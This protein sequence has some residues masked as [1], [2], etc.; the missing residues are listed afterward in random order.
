MNTDVESIFYRALFSYS[1]AYN[2]FLSG[3]L[4]NRENVSKLLGI[5]Y[6]NLRKQEDDTKDS[7]VSLTFRY[8]SNTLN[9]LVYMK[10]KLNYTDLLENY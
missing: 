10:K 4:I 2:D 6:F 1:S 5:L 8:E 3:T 9:A 7:I